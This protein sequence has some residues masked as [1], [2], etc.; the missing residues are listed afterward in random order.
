MILTVIATTQNRYRIKL[1]KKSQEENAL[2]AFIFVL[3]FST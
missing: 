1:H 2:L 3:E